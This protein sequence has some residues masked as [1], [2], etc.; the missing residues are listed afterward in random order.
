MFLGE[1][2]CT[3][4]RKRGILLGTWNVR[5]LYRAGALK[6]AAR[7]LA[8]YKLDLVGVQEVRRDKGGTVGAGDYNFFYGKGNENHQLGTGFFVHQRIAS[9]VKRVEFVSDRMLYIVLRGRW[10]NIIA[11]NVHT[12]SEEKSDGSKDSFYEELE[13]VLI[14]FLSK[15]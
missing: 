9:A 12:P 5:S 4:K 2:S 1:A 8:R 13:Q 14:I 7:E 10:C 11:L 6:A 15:I 3:R